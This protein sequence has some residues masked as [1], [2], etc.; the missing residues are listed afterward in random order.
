MWPDAPGATVQDG[1][2]TWTCS[3]PDAQLY[4]QIRLWARAD[5]GAVDCQISGNQLSHARRVISTSHM[6]ASV[7]RE[8]RIQ[9]VAQAIAEEHGI[10]N[11]Y[12]ANPVDQRGR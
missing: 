4:A 10:G 8:N 2:L 9:G 3:R 6:R 12:Q 11:K 1:S 7:V 5:H